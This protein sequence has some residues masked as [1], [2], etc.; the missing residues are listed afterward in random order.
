AINRLSELDAFDI[1]DD[2]SYAKALNGMVG[3]VIPG[4]SIDTFAAGPEGTGMVGHGYI[5]TRNGVASASGN[6]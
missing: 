6:P 5:G 1:I 3:R 4:T 2:D